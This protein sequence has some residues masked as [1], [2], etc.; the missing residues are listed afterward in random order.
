MI[1]SGNRRRWSLEPADPDL[2]TEIAGSAGLTGATAAVL[3]RRGISTGREAEMLLH[4]S[5]AD[6]PD[7]RLLPDVDKVVARVEE[8]L[9]RGER[10]AVHGHDDADGVTASIVMVDALTELG[11]DVSVYIPDRRTEGHGFNR[12]E[13]ARLAGEGV[14]LIITVDSCV[15]EVDH[16]AYAS[17]L[18]MDTIVTDHHEIPPSLPDAVA[19]VNTKLPDSLY[20]Y[21]TMAG[22]GVAWRVAELLLEEL[23]HRRKT[24]SAPWLGEQWPDEAIALAAIGSIADRVPLTGDN[25]IIVTE[26]LKAMPWVVRPGLRGLLGATGLSGYAVEY[27]DAQSILGSVFGRVSD[28]KGNNRAYEMLAADDVESAA[29]IA[30]E[31]IE[32]RQ[33]WRRSANEAWTT[34]ER[35][36]SAADTD[37][38][39]VIIEV[40]VPIEVMGGVTSRLA[41]QTQKPCI[42][43]VKK[44]G[45]THA[46]ARGPAGYNIVEALQSMGELFLGYGGHPRAAGFSIESTLVPEFLSRM[47]AHAGEHPPVLVPR[48]VDAELD[49]REATIEVAREMAELAPFGQAWGRPVL[50]SRGVT[51][52]VIGAAERNGLRFRTPM[53]VPK[54]PIDLFYR[55]SAADDVLFASEVD[56]GSAT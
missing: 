32:T 27:D 53:R 41:E 9:E 7:V 33:R 18:G 1:L 24:P 15:S 25:R 3:V 26:G 28:G 50:L 31:L 6:L 39:V 14:K 55:L 23:A 22:A 54:N 17:E 29:V 5:V 36:V 44:N 38:P 13:L 11:A 45:E 34:I 52:E 48:R 51:R 10:I 16:I 21:R 2:M 46:E 56:R 47:Q 20:P 8:A 37:T 35:A 49:I 30:R 42:L 4:P 19:I 40:G 12:V 43:M